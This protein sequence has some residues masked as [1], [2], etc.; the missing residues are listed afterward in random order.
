MVPITISELKRLNKENGGHWFDKASMRFFNSEIE[1]KLY[2]GKFFITSERMELNDDKRYTIRE[3][4]E[5]YRINTVGKFQAFGNL[6]Q[7]ILM[8]KYLLDS[9][10]HRS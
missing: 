9:N 2:A 6:D 10:K 7:A 4:S 1:S 3:V 5:G 8:I